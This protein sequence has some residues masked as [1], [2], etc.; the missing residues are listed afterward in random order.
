MQAHRSILLITALLAL[1]SP[2]AAI[3]PFVSAEFELQDQL[4]DDLGAPVLGPVDLEYRIWSSG[5]TGKLLY[6]QVYAAVPLGVD[7]DFNLRVGP[8]GAP[9]SDPEAPLTALVV[10]AVAINFPGV[11]GD[12]FAEI[13]VVGEPGPRPRIR[14]ASVPF[15]MRAL[16][17]N[18]SR[19]ADTAGD[20]ATPG[21]VDAAIIDSIWEHL[22]VDGGPPNKDP[23]EGL[24]D[25]D[26]DGTPNWI[27][28]DNDDDGT[29]DATEFS[30][31]TDINLATPKLITL[32][33]NAL[34]GFPT[35]LLVTGKGFRAGLSATL[36]GNPTPIASVTASTFQ[37][38]VP[39]L[40]LGGHPLIVKNLNGEVSNS[41]TVTSLS[42]AMAKPSALP[43]SSVGSSFLSLETRGMD[44]LV[45]G[46]RVT[47]RIDTMDDGQLALGSLSR[48]PEFNA[49]IN[50][51]SAGRL[52]ML[53]LRNALFANRVELLPDLD[54]DGF[55]DFGDRI[56]I[57]TL[58]RNVG[59]GEG[60]E[61]AFDA[62]DGFLGG[63]VREHKGSVEAIVFHDRDGNGDLLGA[64]ELVV[65]E[66]RGSLPGERSDLAWDP[67]GGLAYLSHDPSLA[68]ALRLLWDR[69]GNGVLE[70]AT[71]LTTGSVDCVGADFDANGR[72]VVVHG[73]DSDLHLRRDLD[74]NGDLTGPGEDLSFGIT[75]DDG[76]DV[77]ASGNIAIAA[78][79]GD[80]VLIHDRNGDGAFVDL[81]EIETIGGQTTSSVAI[82]RSG[83]GT[84]LML[85]SHGISLDPITPLP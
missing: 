24:Q 81:N 27:D 13:T 54:D 16:E 18:R 29:I 58:E 79:N 50:W 9:E 77:D 22:N 38:G 47:Y 53:S 15:A 57:D 39:P 67:V 60:L 36:S 49:D 63:Y 83:N 25:T 59:K 43:G 48:Y 19:F 65:A 26:G 74:G 32:S 17:T 20:I 46:S 14:L 62:A 72:L 21:G 71:D 11:G 75:A 10:A 40:L 4:L 76:C 68:G 1:A 66:T 69:D 80:L 42:P 30:D 3:P 56:L 23:R 31:G 28:S 44:Q 70:I 73:N 5:F 61:I 33:G 64:N 2:I 45:A 82:A 84:L 55:F 41:L 7:G 51:N 6:K 52:Y 85:T 8:F 34:T 12:R 37:I 35:T 78:T